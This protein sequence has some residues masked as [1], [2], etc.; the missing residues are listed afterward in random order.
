MARLVNN[1]VERFTLAQRIEHWV[2]TLSFTTLAITGI[3][4][5]YA[6]AGWAEL[7]IG[8]MGGI[9]MVR[10]I[11]RMAAIV[12]MFVSIYHL[13]AV[14]Y[15]VFV[16][17]VR[18]SM[19]PTPKD[20]VDFL[21]ML[22]YNL[23]LAKN[24]PRFD[25]YSYEEKLEYWAV[26]W[27]TAIMAITGFM[28]WNPIATTRFLPGEFVPAAKAAHGGEALLAVLAII[29]WHIYNVHV[30]HFNKSMF[31]GKLTREEMEHEHPLELV[32][33]QVDLEQPPVPR[34]VIRR[35]ERIF[36]PVA[37]VVTLVWLMGVYAFTSFES[38]AIT[39]VPRRTPVVVFAPFTPTPAPPV[40]TPT[41]RPLL[42]TPTPRGILIPLASV[43]SFQQDVLPVL[44][45]RCGQC[46]GTIAGL[47]L[48]SYEGI[49][50]GGNSGPA[51]VPGNPDESLLVQKMQGPHPVQLSKPELD[52]LGA[53][54]AAGAPDN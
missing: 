16:H 21:D 46:H 6:G 22:R 10:V 50:A 51:V 26:V 31:T 17:R 18:L 32:R 30:K 48:T 20:V 3:P 49:K 15:K 19:L 14:A 37:A 53:W 1:Y 44:E 25:R 9:E 38:T 11:H 40:A 8:L 2:L 29:T 52:L 24:R 54:I 13:I 47:N 34:E 45:M 12:L 7:A 41:P 43:P 23:G 39:T 36:M 28:L 35:R 4:Q 27:G 42:V 5:R 33:L